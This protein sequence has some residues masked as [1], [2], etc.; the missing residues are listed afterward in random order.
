MLPLVQEG[1]GELLDCRVLSA[2][3]TVMI[4]LKCSE[5]GGA[6]NVVATFNNKKVCCEVHSLNFILT[7]LQAD[8]RLLYVYIKEDTPSQSRPFTNANNTAPAR[9]F[10]NRQSGRQAQSAFDDVDMDVDTDA[11]ARGGSYQ[12][13]R[14]GFND[15][16]SPPRGP[17]R[18]Y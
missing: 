14:F 10:N 17:R 6:E 7:L 11:G 1:G 4:E 15:R 18:R 8:G 2:K 3:P 12:D 5:K 16:R 13:G 9:S